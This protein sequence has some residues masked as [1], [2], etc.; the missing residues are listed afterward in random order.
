MVLKTRILKITRCVFTATLSL[1][2]KLC[3]LIYAMDIDFS[4][5]CR[6]F[7]PRELFLFVRYLMYKTIRKIFGP[8]GL[9]GLGGLL[10]Y[11][12]VKFISR[13]VGFVASVPLAH[14][15]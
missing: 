7:C 8:R 3:I 12:T 14:R 10:C 9:K 15:V 11:I 6:V 13:Y 4:C 1:Q 2:E 5:S